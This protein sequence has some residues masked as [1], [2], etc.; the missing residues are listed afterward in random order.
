MRNHRL[1]ITRNL[2]GGVSAIAMLAVPAVA[3][4][5]DANADAE[6][7]TAAQ[8]GES[9]EASPEFD[10]SEDAIIVTGIR[11]SLEKSL[12]IKRNSYGV[13][14]A[15][16]A[17]DIG[18]FPDTNLAESLQ[19]IP[20]VSIDRQ[21]GE[22]STVTVRGFG[23]EFNLVTLNGRQMPTSTLGDGASPPSSR[24]FDFANLASEGIAGVE[25][26]KT[27]RASVPTGG[28]GSV[29]NIKTTRPLNAPGLRGSVG[30]KLVYDSSRNNGDPVTPE[31]SGIISDTFAGD[32]I[33][34]ALT[35]SYQKRKASVNTASV[36]YRD[37]YLG[38]ENNWGSLAMEGDPRF[39]NITNRPGPNDVYEVPQNGSYVLTDIDRERINGQLVLQYRPF[40]SLTATADYTYS[41]NEI[42]ARNSSVGIWFNHDDTTSAWKDGPIAGPIFY[43]EAFSPTQ[44]TDLSYS[45]SL[46]ANRSENK[47]LGFNLNWDA[48]DNLNLALDFHSSSAESKPTNRF[49]TSTSVGTAVYGINR[50]TIDFTNDL[51]IIYYTSD[52]GMDVE[53]VA[54]R[55]A[56]GNSF[57]NAYQ[58]D[59]IQ[60]VQFNGRYEFDTSSPISL[61][62]GASYLENKVR[63]AYGFIQNDTWGGAGPASDIPDDIFEFETLPDKFKS[64]SGSGDPNL[65]AGYYNFNFERFVDLID[66]LYGTCGGDGICLADYTTD[67][68]IKE[69]TSAAYIQ[70]NSEF[71]LFDRTSHLVAG[72]RYE[73]TDID[74][75]ALVPVPIGTRWV[76]VNE[77]NLIFSGDQDFTT[78]KGS[79]DYWLPSVDFDIEII[80][81]VKLRASYSQTIT[82]AS[83]NN[84]QGG[85]SLDQ[86]FRIGGGTGSQGDPGLLPYKSTNLD[87]SAEWYYDEAS[88][89]SAGFFNKD[90]K[91]FIGT[92]RID[93]TAFGLTNPA[94]GSRADAA[95]AALGEN[96]SLQAIRQYIFDNADPATVQK[97]GTD[98]NGFTTGNILGTAADQPLNFE[99]A[100]PANNDQTANLYGFE[101]AIQHNFWDTGFGVVLNYTIVNGDVKFDN[102]LPATATQFALT[103]LSDSAN[104]VAF[105]DKNGIQARVAYNW[106]DE[107]L[108]G[109][110]PNPFYTEAY[111]QVDANVSYEF[112]N[113]VSLFAEVINLT[114]SQQRGHRRTKDNVTFV[115]PGFARY[116]VGA[117]FKF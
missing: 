81:N 96:A 17:E 42:E 76:A 8:Q 72:L 100:I 51:P 14:D 48:T 50:Q 86:L 106:R 103:G 41:R 108:A 75:A 60:Q 94:F 117:R 39:A 113:G 89:V 57:R 44:L 84:L 98:A 37:G 116:N 2:L 66:S 82:R 5:Q 29:I 104:A 97:T 69:K 56:T 33:G 78:L 3:F 28:I 47:S 79:Y 13:V 45:G 65:P 16:S 110:G 90:V 85:Q 107:F 77:F 114:G 34:I 70:A 23:P 67:R 55:V 105:Y 59:E 88:Y 115:Q 35:A 38:S 32:K 74:S 111:G 36:E 101:F 92:G 22:G 21:N 12:D 58:R 64:I 95:R 71:D 102:S 25:V 9:P 109:S 99:I 46:T 52:P 31:F 11:A 43:S 53:N 18:K 54:N 10:S 62:F 24:S 40:D 19:R 1:N 63:S 68:R 73:N 87:F 49:G 20:G 27:G 30:A 26:Y 61:D 112:A 15:I 6:T 91:N 83:Y 4:A 80:T 93:S 7:G